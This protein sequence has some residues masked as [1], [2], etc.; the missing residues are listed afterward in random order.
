MSKKRVQGDPSAAYVR[1]AIAARRVGERRCACGESRPKALISKREPIMCHECWRK[2]EAKSVTDDHHPAGENNDSLTV[3]IPV[4][5]H[6]AELNVAQY[7]WPKPTL[8]NPDASPLLARAACIRGY[9]DTNEYLVD[10][11]LLPSA[12]VYELL[13]T[14][15]TEKFGQKW[16]LNTEL[17]RFVPKRPTTRRKA[18]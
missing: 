11:L 14:L 7:D 1:R 5:D 15:L 9:I 2:Q 13:D 6:R 18:S 17:V 16:W 3:P 12:E 8:E 10:N 4:N